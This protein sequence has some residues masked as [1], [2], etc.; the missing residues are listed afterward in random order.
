MYE[1]LAG[2]YFAAAGGTPGR[3]VVNHCGSLCRFERGQL[4][5]VYGT[6]TH[7]LTIRD[8][9]AVFSSMQGLLRRKFDRAADSDIPA[10][11]LQRHRNR[12]ETVDSVSGYLRE[13]CQDYRHMVAEYASC[14]DVIRLRFEDLV[15]SPESTMRGLAA[16]LGVEFTT[17]L[18]SPTQFGVAHG[19]NSS[20]SREGGTIHQE[21][22]ED[23]KGRIGP[24][25]ARYIEDALTDEMAALGYQRLDQ[26]GPSVLPNGPLLSDR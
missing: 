20:F 12:A 8:P 22:A 11:V 17:A 10:S 21:A 2:A 19:P 18:L 24:A 1:S 7:V 13:F 3:T 23:W 14:S 15:M 25:D 6:G 26:P 16:Q 4:D 9:R 5:N